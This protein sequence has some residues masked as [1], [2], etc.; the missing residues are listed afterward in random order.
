LPKEGN[1]IT[2]KVIRDLIDK[3]AL[4]DI[5][6]KECDVVEKDGKVTWNMQGGI[7]KDFEFA[8]VELDLIK[9]ELKKLDENNKLSL[10]IYSVYMKFCG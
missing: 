10:D 9:M 3:L 8:S 7:P 4:S 5:D 1:I 6:I 2:I